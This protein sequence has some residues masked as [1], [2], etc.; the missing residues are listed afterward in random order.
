[1]EPALSAEELAAVTP[2]L[3]RSGAGG[4]AWA[5]LRPTRLRD[6]PPAR[7]LQQAYRL[8]ALHAALNEQRVAKAFALLRAAGIEPLLGKG[9]AAASLYPGPGLR[10]H[11][12]VDLYVPADV[13]HAA[14]VAL[15]SPDGK[16]CAVDMHRG[17]AELDDRAPEELHRRSR[18]GGLEGVEV[19]VFGAED[20]LRLLAL[21]LLRHGAWRP[22]WLCD[23][24]AAIES[25]PPGFDWGYFL[26]G[27]PR[28]GEWVACALRLA[29]ELLGAELAD[30]PSEVR[31]RRLPR[32]LVP[33]VLRQWEDASFEPHGTRA[34]M[35]S[36]LR[37][38][39]GV[40]RALEVRWPN[41][42]EASVGRR[43]PFNELPRL[44]F[45]IAECVVRTARF[46]LALPRILRAAPPR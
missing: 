42:V 40:L 12:D 17:F 8:N 22:L 24:A 13:Y 3:L 31:E 23:V 43:A 33:T 35:A 32:W 37:R 18:L 39:A 21:H 34:A 27:D 20:H 25:R 19:R 14:Q 2:L 28:R 26:S 4:L 16:T 7:E 38:P 9:W 10:P 45:Q 44:P 36:Y 15:S 46:A 30:A 6:A 1:M 11:G 5:R 29:H 41:G